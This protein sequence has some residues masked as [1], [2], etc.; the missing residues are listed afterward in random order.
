[1]SPSSVREDFS[2]RFDKEAR[3]IASLNH[4]NIIKVEHN[5]VFAA[6]R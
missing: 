2:E 3:A 1:M 6:T 4:P 5:N